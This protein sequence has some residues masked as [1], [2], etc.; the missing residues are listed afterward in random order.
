MSNQQDSSRNFGRGV[1]STNPID[2]TSQTQ[3]PDFINDLNVQQ[4]AIFQMIWN[5]PELSLNEKIACMDELMDKLT[6]ETKKK[7]RSWRFEH[8]KSTV[9]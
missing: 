1:E 3:L 5:N 9:G 6:L 4:K 2:P 8:D 7:Y